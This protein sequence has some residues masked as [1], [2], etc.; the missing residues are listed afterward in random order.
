MRQVEAQIM[1]QVKFCPK[2]GRRTRHYG[3]RGRTDGGC[4][5]CEK[6][7]KIAE[8]RAARKRGAQT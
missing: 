1:A 6:L 7:R 2:C 8:A 5:R 3:W 4:M